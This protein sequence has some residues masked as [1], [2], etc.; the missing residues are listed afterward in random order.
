MPIVFDCPCGKRIRAKDGSAGRNAPCPACG[1]V[2]EVPAPDGV[3]LG[4]DLGDI[5]APSATTP[6][7]RPIDA[8]AADPLP[9][10]FTRQELVSA[11]AEGIARERADWHRRRRGMF[12][13]ELLL[14]LLAVFSFFAMVQHGATAGVCFIVCIAGMAV[15]SKIP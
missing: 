12:G 3:D 13:G 10:G 1:Q 2:L 11:I 6:A 14:G 7:R 8:P 9:F 5:D 15:L 4:I